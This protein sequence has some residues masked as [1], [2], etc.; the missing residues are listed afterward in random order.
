MM[1]AMTFFGTK[2]KRF[3]PE[4]GSKTITFKQKKSS[5]TYQIRDFLKNS[6]RCGFFIGF[7]ESVFPVRN[8]DKQIA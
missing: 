2:F 6:T 7:L 1:A 5:F 8:K 3:I 4:I